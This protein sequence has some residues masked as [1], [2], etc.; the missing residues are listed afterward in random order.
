VIKQITKMITH[1]F[2][3]NNSGQSFLLKKS[4]TSVIYLLTE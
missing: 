1:Y 4:V 2:L 3:N